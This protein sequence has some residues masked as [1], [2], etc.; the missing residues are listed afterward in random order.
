MSN[1]RADQIAI[2]YY[3]RDILYFPEELLFITNM[4][5]TIPNLFGGNIFPPLKCNSIHEWKSPFW[6]K[7]DG[8]C[9]TTHAWV[10][11]SP[12]ISTF[13]AYV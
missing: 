1:V 12:S 5:S 4:S 9:S 3:L 7:P 2:F 6:S 11:V 8:A 10:S 13:K